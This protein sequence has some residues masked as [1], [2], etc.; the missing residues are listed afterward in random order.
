MT[1]DEVGAAIGRKITAATIRESDGLQQCFYS[2]GGS[3]PDASPAVVVWFSTGSGEQAAFDFTKANGEP[4]SGVGDEAVWFGSE[5]KVK[6]KGG[7]LDVNMTISDVTINGGD[8]KTV[9]VR[10]AR[11]ALERI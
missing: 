5:L 6:A 2:F 4:V 10:L 8:L 9:A 7:I 11:M 1:S 3:D